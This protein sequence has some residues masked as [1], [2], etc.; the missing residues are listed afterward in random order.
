MIKCNGPAVELKGAER[1]LLV[2]ASVM[3]NSLEK[4]AP[5]FLDKLFKAMTLAAT[6]QDMP[7]CKWVKENIKNDANT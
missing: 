1:I 7:A 6:V 4:S 5:G 2:E 3:L